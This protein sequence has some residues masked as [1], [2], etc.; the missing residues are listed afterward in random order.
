MFKH[1]VINNF[2]LK[3]VFFYGT[4]PTGVNG[5]GGVLYY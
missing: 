2:I 1:E 3:L 5:K 4:V